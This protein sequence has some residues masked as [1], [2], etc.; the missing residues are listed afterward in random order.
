MQQLILKRL[1]PNTM[2]DASV[3]EG[4]SKLTALLGPMLPADLKGKRVLDFGCG[5]GGETAELARLGALA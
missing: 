2:M 4:R 5:E 3:Y 1:G